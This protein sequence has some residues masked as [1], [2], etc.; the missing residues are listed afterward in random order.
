[1]KLPR[2]YFL[3]LAAGA[4][5]LPAV[6]RVARAQAYPTRPVRL[7]VPVAP[8]GA[9]DLVARLM[10][11]WLSEQL[12]QPF[13]IENR[14]GAG[15]NIGTEAVVRAPADGYTLLLVAAANAINATL[16]DKLNFNFIRDI[17][18]VAGITR[19]PEVMVVHPSVPAKTVPEFIAYAKA[20]PGKLTMAS[21][22][23]GSLSHVAGELFKMMA[24]VDMVHVPYRGQG[25]ALTDLLGGQVQVMFAI[26]VASIEYI[27][28]G[29]LRAL[30]V[31]AA[32]RSDALP[33][34]PTVGEFVLDYEA[35]NWFG[36]CAPKATPAE[37][38][39]KLN[40][41]INASLA[42]PKIKARLAEWGATALPGS[43]A[44]FGKLIAEETEKW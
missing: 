17:A 44:D 43:P 28:T 1:M 15:T 33:D 26:T 19:A 7:I 10:G 5:A 8:G 3:H 9:Y 16:Y 37:I 18:P 36:V 21:G 14:P 35:S 29:R 38:V 13:I 22:G 42:E 39:D 12:G 4:A 20:N 6:S 31:T 23:I 11:Q 41:E 30:A 27:K 32:T 34:I 25:P 40:K 2:R 24:G